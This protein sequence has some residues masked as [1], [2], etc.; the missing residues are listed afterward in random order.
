[1]GLRYPPLLASPH[2]R[3]YPISASRSSDD[4]EEARRLIQRLADDGGSIQMPFESSPWGSHY[5]QAF[6]KFGVF[7]AFDVEDS[8]PDA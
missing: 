6:D 4:V 3:G 7:W 2:V 1:M 8:A 5:G